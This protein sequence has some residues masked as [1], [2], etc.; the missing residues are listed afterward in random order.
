M[1]VCLGDTEVPRYVLDVSGISE[2]PSLITF[3]FIG[4]GTMKWITITN[5]SFLFATFTPLPCTIPNL[6]LLQYLEFHKQYTSESMILFSFVKHFLKLLNK[7]A[8]CVRVCV[9]VCLCVSNKER[10]LCTR[11]NLVMS[12][13]PSQTHL[14]K[15]YLKL[16]TSAF[17]LGF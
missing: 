16:M 10:S 1:L 12:Q 17:S 3:S 9:S 6:L 14:P 4:A 8:S 11:Q 7:T 15:K 5:K 13:W 2:I